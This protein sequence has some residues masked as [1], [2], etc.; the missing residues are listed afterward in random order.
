MENSRPELRRLTRRESLAA[1]GSVTAGGLLAAC[2]G[3]DEQRTAVTT[4]T[5]ETTSVPAKTTSTATAALFDEG[6]SCQ[7]TA[8]L[9]EGPFY[10]DVDRIRSDIREGRE[11][12]RMRLAFRVRDA[13]SCDPLPNALVEV[14]H[15]DALGAYSG[16]EGSSGEE[17]FLRGGQVT[18]RD[19][20]AEFTTIYPGWYPGRTVHLH[21]KI[22]PSGSQVVTTQ[23]FTAREFDERVYESAPYDERPGRD[24]FNDDDGIFDDSLVLTLREERGGVLG[25]TTFDVEAA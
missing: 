14:W 13:D 11:G 25:F 5:G 3:D 15:C 7:V 12:T 16:V 1:I 20:I 4:T 6:E 2:G 8:E 21:I 9:T 22:A 24:T 10:I 18:N 19:G 23:V 17:T